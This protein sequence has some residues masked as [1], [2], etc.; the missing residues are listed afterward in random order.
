MKLN[1]F[2][3]L[4]LKIFSKTFEK[5]YKQGLTDSFNF[6]SAPAH[7]YKWL[8]ENT[9]EKAIKYKRWKKTHKNVGL[10]IMKFTTPFIHPFK[11]K[12]CIK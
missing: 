1:L 12:R 11:R 9:K 5:V 3:K 10:F 6:L 7:P 4:I 8:Y 2:E